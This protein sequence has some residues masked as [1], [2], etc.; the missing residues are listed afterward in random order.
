M[1][2]ATPKDVLDRHRS[3]IMN[4][5]GVVGVAYGISPTEPGAKRILVYTTRRDRPAGLPDEIEG[6]AVETVTRSKG[7]RAL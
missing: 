5:E 7:F 6:H 2:N 3:E 1:S 4:L